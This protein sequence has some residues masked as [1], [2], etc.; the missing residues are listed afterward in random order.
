MPIFDFKIIF[1]GIIKI[2]N[3]FSALIL[4]DNIVSKMTMNVINYK[5]LSVTQYLISASHLELITLQFNWM[6]ILLT[7]YCSALL[8]QGVKIPFTK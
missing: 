7:G 8:F 1:N 4:I 6:N 2:T 3:L 5:D